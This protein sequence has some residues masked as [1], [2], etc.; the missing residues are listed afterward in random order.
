MADAFRAALTGLHWRA[1]SGYR[2]VADQGEAG[3]FH[4]TYK[5]ETASGLAGE[6]MGWLWNQ[7]QQ[8]R[9]AVVVWLNSH[10]A[11]ASIAMVV[12]KGQGFRMET[13]Y[14]VDNAQM[15]L[16][17]W[18]MPDLAIMSIRFGTYS[19]CILRTCFGVLSDAADRKPSGFVLL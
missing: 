8:L 18:P 15:E 3:C 11:W 10:A 4:G 9:A 7:M 16:V 19:S 14:R 6:T 17:P 12:H 13:D 5:V 2:A 1:T